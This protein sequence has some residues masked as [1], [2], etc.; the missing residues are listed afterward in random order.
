VA[1]L[2]GWLVLMLSDIDEC[3][4]GSANCEHY[5]HDTAG[6]YECSCR[7]GYKMN[8][9]DGS[10]CDGQCR[11]VALPSV[12]WMRSLFNHVAKKQRLR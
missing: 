1:L 7:P 6:S 5:C 8:P 12:G 2:P 9:T 11:S 3:R 10:K 4:S